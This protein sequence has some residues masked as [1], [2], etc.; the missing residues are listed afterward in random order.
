MKIT[1]TLFMTALLLMSCGNNSEEYAMQVG[2][3]TTI[4]VEDVYDAGTV[5]KGTIIHVE[6]EIKNTGSYPL[7]IAEVKP[8]CSCT[9][10]GYEENPIPPGES[11][12]LKAEVDTD[13]TGTGT[14]NKPITVTANT[15]PSTTT[16]MI[17]ATVN[18]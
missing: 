1:I 4:E 6:F 13:R 16:L 5:A 8:S 11:T 9:V 10:P 17:K 12:I 18:N 2:E 14:I 15:K 3:Y 7:I